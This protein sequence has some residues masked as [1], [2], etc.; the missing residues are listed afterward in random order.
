MVTDRAYRPSKLNDAL[1]F[2]AE[3]AS[4]N[5]VIFAGGTDL[6]VRHRGYTGTLPKIEAP[7][8]FVDGIEELLNVSAGQNGAASIGAAVPYSVLEKTSGLPDLLIRSVVKIAAPG[9]RNRGT[10]GGNICNASPAADTVPPLLIHAAVCRIVSLSGERTVPL[11]NFATGPGKTVLAPG[12]LLASVE[13]PPYE[14]THAYYRK[15]G[16][17]KANALS[18]LSV[19][20][21]V[22]NGTDAPEIRIAMGAVGPKALRL[23]GTEEAIR[24]GLGRDAILNALYE[25]IRPIS[26]QRSTADY[27]NA[28]AGNCV[29]E[30]C[31]KAGLAI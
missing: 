18:K 27:R 25:E 8:L 1:M 29:I 26:D 15:I 24:K 16:T 12:E 10:V 5:P 30:F 9:L 20:A 17:R 7:V 23:P 31:E 21:A 11:E 2:L 13:V 3:H 28:V 14:I 22:F 6:M 19:C 4:E